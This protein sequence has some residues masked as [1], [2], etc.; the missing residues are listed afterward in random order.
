MKKLSA[1]P[2]L[3]SEEEMRRIEEW[4]GMVRNRGLWPN[5]FTGPSRRYVRQ[6]QIS[7]R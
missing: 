2:E 6:R 5:A 1:E 7:I 4:S 3:E